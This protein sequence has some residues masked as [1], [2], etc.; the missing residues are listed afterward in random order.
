[1]ADHA[2]ERRLQTLFADASGFDDASAFAAGLE[3]RLNRVWAVRRVAIGTAGL[4]GGGVAVVQLVGSDWLSQLQLASHTSAV[5]AGRSVGGMLDGVSAF[6]P[7]LRLMPLGG[8]AGWLIAGL[9]GLAI[10]LLATRAL[11]QL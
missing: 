4:I 7:V 1:M 6:A 11:E 9:V 5:E 2:F 3:S 8:E 10:A